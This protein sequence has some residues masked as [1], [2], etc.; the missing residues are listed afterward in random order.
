[1]W[2]S[3][4]TQPARRRQNERQQRKGLQGWVAEGSRIGEVGDIREG[5]ERMSGQG[6]TGWPDI[7]RRHVDRP[8]TKISSLSLSL[9]VSLFL[10]MCVWVW[11][12]VRTSVNYAAVRGIV[13]SRS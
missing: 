5:W 9:F 7:E 4:R 8:R 12:W 10:C 11:V 1:M 6:R 2:I 13:P 3:R